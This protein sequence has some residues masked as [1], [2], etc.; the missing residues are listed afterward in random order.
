MQLQLEKTCYVYIDDSQNYLDVERPRSGHTFAFYVSC[1]RRNLYVYTARAKVN[2]KTYTKFV[3]TNVPKCDFT[4]SLH[5]ACYKYFMLI[6]GIL[7]GNI[8][9]L[10]MSLPNTLICDILASIILLYNNDNAVYVK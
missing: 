8:A 5:Y 10:F 6:V 2:G 1:T 3:H 4:N 9:S 7:S